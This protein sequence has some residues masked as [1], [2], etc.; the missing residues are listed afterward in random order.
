MEITKWEILHYKKKKFSIKDFCHLFTNRQVSHD[1]LEINKY[2][3][4]LANYG[5]IE[6]T[7]FFFK[8]LLI[9]PIHKLA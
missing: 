2:I 8:L 1:L 7:H 3:S 4:Q 5:H 9:L 6:K